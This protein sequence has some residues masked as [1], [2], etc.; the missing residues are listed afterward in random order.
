MRK[1]IGTIFLTSI[2][3]TCFAQN[4][5]AASSYSQKT[6]VIEYND[7]EA[8]YTYN[9][10]AGVI[11]HDEQGYLTL[12]FVV[13]ITGKTDSAKY[14]QSVRIEDCKK[15]FGYLYFREF[16]NY[17][18]FKEQWTSSGTNS[19]DTVANGFCRIAKEHHFY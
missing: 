11:G 1:S 2:C 10:K 3:F 15:G 7:Q 12:Q 9:S 4:V 17:L 14:K 5:Q 18:Y 8:S 13:Q 6:G 19:S 16:D